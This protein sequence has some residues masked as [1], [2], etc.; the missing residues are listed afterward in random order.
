MP[1]ADVAA[2]AFGVGAMA[3]TFGAATGARVA[4]VGFVFELTR[5]YEVIVPL[6]IATVLADLVYNALCRHSLMTEKLHRRGLHVSRHYGVDLFTTM[7]VDR[8]MSTDVATLPADGTIGDA[9]QL[10]LANG[11]GAYPLV[12]EDG[13]VH[14]IVSRGD[15]L[16]TELA[17]DEPVASCASPDVVTVAP[18]DRAVRVL[19]VMLD[20][21]VE[22]VPVVAGGRLVGICTRT[23]LLEVRRAQFELER[24]AGS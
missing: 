11:H 23:D 2:G 8:V 10:M 17:D 12:G 21:G 24:R 16:E 7:A 9:R 5:D 19:E 22:H 14:G 6:M 15:V 20:E 13:A 18:T 1:G 3:A 4:A